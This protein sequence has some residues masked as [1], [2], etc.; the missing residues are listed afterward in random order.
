MEAAMGH[1]NTAQQLNQR[2]GTLDAMGLHAPAAYNRSLAH[3]HELAARQAELGERMQRFGDAQTGGQ[4]FGFSPTVNASIG[5]NFK[6]TPDEFQS[7]FQALSPHISGHGLDPNVLAAQYPEDTAHMV[8]AYLNH[9]DE[10]MKAGDPLYRASELGNAKQVQ[11]MLTFMP[12]NK[13]DGE[14][15]T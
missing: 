14:K 15:R 2:A 3:G 12:M 8:Q 11:G 7:G 1:L 6:G 5:S 10:I 13:D 9:S 4:D